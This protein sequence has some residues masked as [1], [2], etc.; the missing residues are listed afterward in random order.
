METLG[1][2]TEFLITE[3]VFVNVYMMLIWASGRTRPICHAATCG[4]ESIATEPPRRRESRTDLAPVG[5][6]ASLGDDFELGLIVDRRGDGVEAEGLMPS[7]SNRRAD[8]A[9]GT[10]VSSKAGLDGEVHD[11]QR[12]ATRS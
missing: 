11:V 2:S 4:S 5:P 7:M 9:G 3:S 8:E 6:D 12:P 10:D 1:S